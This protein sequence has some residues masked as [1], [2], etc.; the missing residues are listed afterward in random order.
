MEDIMKGPMRGEL[1]VVNDGRDL[2]V[3]RVVVTHIAKS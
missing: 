1:E 2:L 3:L